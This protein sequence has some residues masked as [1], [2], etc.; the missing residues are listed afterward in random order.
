QSRRVSSWCSRHLH[1]GSVVVGIV[2]G[3]AFETPV[4][5]QVLLR[6]LTNLRLDEVVVAFGVGDRAAAGEVVERRMDYGAVT[7]RAGQALEEVGKYGCA[8]HACEPRGEGVGC[9]RDIKQ[10]DHLGAFLAIAL[11]GRIPDAFVVFESLDQPADIV[12][13]NRVAAEAATAACQ[14]PGERLVLGR[15]IE[16]AGWLD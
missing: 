16:K 3:Q 1:R 15:P 10:L 12:A 11:V 7:L 2:V 8:R 6:H 9:G 4:Y 5:P 14:G 13:G